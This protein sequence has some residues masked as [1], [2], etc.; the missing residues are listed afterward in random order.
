V[1]HM[2]RSSYSTLFPG[3]ILPSASTN[4]ESFMTLV[5][6]KVVP[7]LHSAI[8]LTNAASKAAFCAFL[9][10]FRMLYS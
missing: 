10:P 9:R 2:S 5:V 8:R 1:N 7:W 3:F 6:L 4:R